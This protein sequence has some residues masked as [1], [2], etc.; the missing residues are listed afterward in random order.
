[1]NASRRVVITACGAVLPPGKSPSA[2]LNGL[3]QDFSPFER[4]A[5]DPETAVLPV[6]DFDLKT[7]TG[8]FKNARY[9]HRGQELCL[10]AAILAVQESG[11]NRERLA[12]AGLFLGC[13][14]NLEAAPR[15]DKALWLMDYLPNTL[16]AVTAE[17]LGV[18]GEN[19]TIQTACAASTQALG[20]AFHAIRAGRIDV[21]LAGGGDS[22]LSARGIR[23][24]RQAGVL[25][26]GFDR[27]ERACRPFDQSRTGFAVGEGAAMFVLESLEHA[28]SRDAAILAE[29]IGAASS[30][31]GQGLTA[32]DP[33][34]SA[35][36]SCVRRCLDKMRGKS[37]L[38]AA[39]GTGTLL[40]DAAESALMARVAPDALAVC[41]FKSRLGHLA[42][43][44]GCAELAVSLICARA[45]YFPGIANLDEPCR[46]DIPFLRESANL[47]PEAILVQSFGFGGQNACL[48]VQPWT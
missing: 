32:P 44:C 41:A 18:H 10:A 46:T 40:N 12:E 20:E 35:A 1:M 39:H 21:T 34:M 14:P 2:I 11:L 16:A 4:S 28:Q 24:Y 45:G 8:R 29:I 13:G 36:E 33:L 22:R 6:P 19:L 23:A 15:P 30:L 5:H 17:I 26:S 31:D 43:A 7:Y 42:S 37:L 9:L 25:A 3:R 47:R 38:I 27:P 48:G